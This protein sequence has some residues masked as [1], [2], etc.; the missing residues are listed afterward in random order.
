MYSKLILS[1]LSVANLPTSYLPTQIHHSSYSSS[2]RLT[3]HALDCWLQLKKMHY[4]K[5]CVHRAPRKTK[6]QKVSPSLTP[7]VLIWFC[8]DCSQT[9]PGRTLDHAVGAAEHAGNVLSLP[10]PTALVLGGSTGRKDVDATITLFS[11]LKPPSA[12]TS[13][14]QQA[15]ELYWVALTGRKSLPSW[16]VLL[17]VFVQNLPIDSIFIMHLALHKQCMLT[18]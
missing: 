2:C 4:Q 6:D 9:V 7:S 10:F 11:F 17:T 16:F 8:S 18:S 12:L 14:P 15:S 5:L 1:F 3:A 13:P